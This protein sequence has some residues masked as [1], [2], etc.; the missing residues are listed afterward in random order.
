ME[1]ELDLLEL[2]HILLKRWKMIILLTLLAAAI[3][4]AVSQFLLTPQYVASASLM[5]M[6]PVEAEKILYQDI[7]VSRQLADTYQIVVHS[8]RVLGKVI[9]ALDLPFSAGELK[10]RVKVDAVKNTEII[11]IDV[12]DSD[13]YQAARISNQIARTFMD[14]ITEI[15][16]VDNVSLIDLAAVPT[17][18]VSPRLKLNVAVAAVLGLM[19]AVGIALLQHYLDQTVKSSADI[20]D[21]LGLTVLGTIPVM[22]EE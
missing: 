4:G 20:Q 5:V 9:Q 16:S 7:Q 14:E 21:L 17:V 11:T 3:S 6:K 22:E 15:M 13:P 12:T 18:P 19:L 1:E 10:N 2:W 8:R